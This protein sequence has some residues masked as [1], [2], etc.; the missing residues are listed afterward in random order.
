MIPQELRIGNWVNLKNSEFIKVDTDNIGDIVNNPAIFS[1]IPLTPEI[2]ERAGFWKNEKR[3]TYVL[4]FKNSADMDIVLFIGAGEDTPEKPYMFWGIQDISFDYVLV[5]KL[6]FV[7]QLQNLIFA[8]CGT[9]LD[10]NL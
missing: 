10:I 8:L 2:L 9:E 4:E 3:G 6:H 5:E 1:P 7:H